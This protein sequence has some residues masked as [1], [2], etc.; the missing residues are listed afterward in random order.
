MFGSD[1]GAHT[2]GTW[3]AL[4]LPSAFVLTCEAHAVS[5][6]VLTGVFVLLAM[7]QDMSVSSKVHEAVNAFISFAHSENDNVWVAP[8]ERL[9]VVTTSM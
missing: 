2:C 8:E 6:L 4:S 3:P 1:T 7:S 5:M 9:S